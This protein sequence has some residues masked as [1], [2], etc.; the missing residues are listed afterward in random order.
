MNVLNLFS[1]I[2]WKR[3]LAWDELGAWFNP[4]QKWLT[5]KIPNTWCDKPELIRILM[6]EMIV[7][8][9]EEEKGLDQF[10]VDWSEDIKDGYV[11]Q[12]YVDDRN[13]IYS[14]IKIVYDYIKDERPAL[15]KAH[16]ESYPEINFNTFAPVNDVPF[17]EAYAENNR[18]EAL[19][20]EK[21]DW[22]LHKIVEL[23]EYI[24][25]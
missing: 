23:R 10:N 19:L 15:V 7:N 8:F 25:T 1:P 18:L 20:E 21:D 16:D 17:N 11:T 14:Q 4:R 22:A 3:S 5:S 13:S 12:E 6:F 9:V 2:R 24:W